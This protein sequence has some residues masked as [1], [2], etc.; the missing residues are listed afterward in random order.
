MKQEVVGAGLIRVQKV[1][2]KL[3]FSTDTPAMN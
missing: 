3:K 1:N 2:D